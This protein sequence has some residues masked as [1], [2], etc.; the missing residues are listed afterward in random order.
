MLHDRDARSRINGYKLHVIFVEGQLSQV[1][2]LF[3][4][5]NSTGQRLSAQEVRHAR[6]NKSPFLEK[7]T[8]LAYSAE[9]KL[10]AR[11]ILSTSQISRMKHIELI[12]ELMLSCA[13]GEVVNK[14]KVLDQAMDPKGGLSE[15]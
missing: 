10:K 4:K 5:I 15:K 6:F 2:E 11:K 8:S 7:A 9:E 14:K 12:S 13:Q 1:I 3:V